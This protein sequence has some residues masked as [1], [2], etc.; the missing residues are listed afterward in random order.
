VEGAG[1]VISGVD[2]GG[3][4]QSALSGLRQRLA[5]ADR[6]RKVTLLRQQIQEL[7]TLEAQAVNALSAQVL[8]LHAAKTLTQPELIS[9]CK[10]VDDVRSQLEQREAELAQLQPPPS[11]APAALAEAGAATSQARDGRTCRQCGAAAVV[12]G[13]P[14]CHACGA[15]LAEVAPQPESGTARP[16]VSPRFCIQCGAQLREKARF[17]PMCGQT[18]AS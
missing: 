13:A 16:E 3:Q 9:L 10:G 11:A 15:R 4:I 6:R 7:R 1:Q 17:C 8:A 5:E 18:I 2:K 12:V 14:F